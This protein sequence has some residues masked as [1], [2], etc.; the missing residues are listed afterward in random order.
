MINYL[1]LRT[2]SF[3]VRHVKRIVFRIIQQNV[4]CVLLDINLRILVILVLKIFSVVT[5]LIV[6]YAQSGII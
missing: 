6:Q 2:V 5:L 1:V 3:H 4:K